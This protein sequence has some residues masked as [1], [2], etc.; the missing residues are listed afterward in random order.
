MDLMAVASFMNQA[1]AAVDYAH[2]NGIVHRDIKPA[3]LM[4]EPGGRVRLAD[5]GI[6][7]P[8]D[9]AATITSPGEVVG[10]ISY[11]APEIIGGKQASPASDIYSLAA[12]AYEMLAG[13]KPYRAETTAGLLEAIR[14]A[15]GPVLA[16]KVPPEAAPALARALSGE[17]AARPDSAKAFAAELSEP[18]TLVLPP[19]APRTEEPEPMAPG[20]VSS[21][22][23]PTILV[24]PAVPQAMQSEGLGVPRSEE[25]AP[26]A[27]AAQR[28]G[29]AKLV[30]IAG[31]VVILA[32]VAALALSNGGPDADAASGTTATAPP[33]S[34]TSPTTIPTTLATTAPAT[35]GSTSPVESV[36]VLLAGQI[37][38][39]LDGL[40]PPD[41]KPKDVREIDEGVHRAIEKWEEGD[42]EGAASALGQ[43]ASQVDRF[44]ES[45]TRDALLGLLAEL[46]EAMSLEEQDD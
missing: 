38:D 26:V 43:A 40:G 6:A 14:R 5:F 27:P 45:E 37:T 46:A 18:G 19:A 3:N 1:A 9:D 31:G 17:P 33:S 13:E 8:L 16:G 23:E 25:P 34:S 30:A 39:L 32:A 35:T 24:S 42:A 44:P 22:D 4:I 41:Y 36:P 11:V 29:S 7:K 15:D 20:R 21:P 2:E 10:T 12:V 28:A